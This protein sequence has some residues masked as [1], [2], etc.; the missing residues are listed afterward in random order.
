MP[1][2]NQ[3]ELVKY[4][5]QETHLKNSLR[6][7][8]ELGTFNIKSMLADELFDFNDYSIATWYRQGVLIQYGGIF[9]GQTY[10]II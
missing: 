6:T 7:R 10:S 4:K 2:P 5:I 3:K 8:A 9:S 1:F